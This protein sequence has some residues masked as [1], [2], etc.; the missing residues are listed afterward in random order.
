ML[1][2]ESIKTLRHKFSPLPAD[3]ENIVASVHIGGLG[4]E[5][6][7]VRACLRSQAPPISV[8]PAVDGKSFLLKETR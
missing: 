3:S 8:A 7:R 4:G 5:S 1:D 2:V 6:L